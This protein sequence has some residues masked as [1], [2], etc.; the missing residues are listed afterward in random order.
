[1][2]SCVLL[3]NLRLKLNITQKEMAKILGKSRSN[4]AN[5]ERGYAIPPGDT[6]LK[7]LDLYPNGELEA[8]RSS[9]EQA[10]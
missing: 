4:I 8:L 10:P 3:K 1:M 9:K 6:L 5:Y 7:V 2:K